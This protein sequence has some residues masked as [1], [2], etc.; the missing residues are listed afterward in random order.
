H[1]PA[2]EA[3]DHSL[4][5]RRDL[6]PV[7]TLAELHEHARNVDA[8]GADILARAAERGGVGEVLDCG[9]PL[10]HRGEEDPDGSR[11]RVAVGVAADLTVDGADIETSA[12]AQAV[13]RLPQRARDLARAAIVHEDQV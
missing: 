8:H 6:L 5:P 7:Q 3:E 10:E 2:R 1:G 13:E 4:A 9:I 11:I 12:A